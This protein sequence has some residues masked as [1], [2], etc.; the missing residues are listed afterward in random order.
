MIFGHFIFLVIF[1]LKFPWVQQGGRGDWLNYFFRDFSVLTLSCTNFIKLQILHFSKSWGSQASDEGI[2]PFFRGSFQHA[3]AGPSGW[4]LD[5]L[6]HHLHYDSQVESLNIVL[7]LRLNKDRQVQIETYSYSF[8]YFP[9]HRHSDQYLKLGASGDIWSK[10]ASTNTQRAGRL[11]FVA[12]RLSLVPGSCWRQ[13]DLSFWRRLLTLTS[14][15]TWFQFV[16]YWLGKD[17]RRLVEDLHV[18]V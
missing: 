14:F 12:C 13:L 10:A 1:P 6:W 18:G 7:Y 17:L 11:S 8:L 16:H 5:R 2:F 4:R 3:S 15:S 9:L